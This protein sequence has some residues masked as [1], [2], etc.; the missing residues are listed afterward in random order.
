[1]SSEPTP[2]PEPDFVGIR[3]DYY[4]DDTLIAF[5]IAEYQ[6]GVVDSAKEIERLTASLETI[7]TAT[8]CA[9][10]KNIAISTLTGT[11]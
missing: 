10:S 5:G 8:A 6:R 11:L 2:L 1:M 9:Y 7:A 3:E 4:N